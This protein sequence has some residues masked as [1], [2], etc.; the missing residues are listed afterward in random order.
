MILASSSPQRRQLLEAAGFQFEVVPSAV[1]ERFDSYLTICELTLLNARQ[2]ALAVAQRH[3]D[4]VVLGADTLVALRGELIGK[5][6]DLDEAAKTLRRLS[7]QV[8][9]VCTSVC[10]VYAADAKSVL[11]HEISQVR[12]HPL[13]ADKIQAYLAKINPLDKAGA[14]A[15]QGAG[16]EVIAEIIGS[17][18]NVVGLPMEKTARA[19]DRFGIK[20]IL[21]A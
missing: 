13:T 20:P 15:A 16:R 19:L 17:Y 1:K 11:F 3:Y 4:S 10:I 18:T 8:H 5:P 7:G 21:T 2:K 14:Y 12:F 9:Q 6:R